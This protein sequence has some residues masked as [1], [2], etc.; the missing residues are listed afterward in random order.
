VAETMA[1]IS[2]PESGS[3]R[4]RMENGE[5]KHYQPSKCSHMK[6]ENSFGFRH[7]SEGSRF[8][9]RQSGA[10]GGSKKEINEGGM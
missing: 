4:E 8:R 6:K 1:R 2:S 9:D 5:E 3:P 7:K 10:S